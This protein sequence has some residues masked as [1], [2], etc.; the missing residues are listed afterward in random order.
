MSLQLAHVLLADLAR[1]GGHRDVSPSR[2]DGVDRRGAP[3]GRPVR[4]VTWSSLGCGPLAGAARP[5]RQ[6]RTRG[7]VVVFR[8][9]VGDAPCMESAAMAD[10][11]GGDVPDREITWRWF[12]GTSAH[13]SGPHAGYPFLADIGLQALSPRVRRPGHRSGCD[14]RHRGCAPVLAEELD[15]ADVADDAGHTRVRLLLLRGRLPAYRR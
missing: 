3:P 7:A 15:V 9:D 8:V 14:R 4:T 10:L 5:P 2:P 12:A 1:A 13:R 11:Y 6:R